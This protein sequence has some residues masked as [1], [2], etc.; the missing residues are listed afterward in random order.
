VDENKFGV[1]LES[2]LDKVDAIAVE[3]RIMEEKFE[4]QLSELKKD[5]DEQL[6]V[7][8]KDIGEIKHD[9]QKIKADNGNN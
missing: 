1:L 8:K 5:V 6:S 4:G 7:L 3:Q 9:V 2:I